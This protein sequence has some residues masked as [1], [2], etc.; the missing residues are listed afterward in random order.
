MT[1]LSQWDAFFW[2]LVAASAPGLEVVQVN[3]SR[4]ITFEQ[5]FWGQLFASSTVASLIPMVL[6]G[7][8]QRYY[9]RGII[10]AGIK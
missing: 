3:V 9:V 2:P 5:T 8:L 6:F 10:G 7:L 1:F 4:A